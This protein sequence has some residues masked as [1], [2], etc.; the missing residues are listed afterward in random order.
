[1]ARKRGRSQA[2]EP[3]RRDSSAA[4]PA[5]HVKTA[6]EPRRALAN[7]ALLA[8]YYL[9]TQTLRQYA[10]SKLPSSSRIRR[11][12]I[13]SVGLSH[14]SPEK[15]CTEDELALGELLD[16]T[17]V[18]RRQ[19]AEIDHGH[20]W[21]QWVGFSQKGDESYVTL[22]DGLKGSIYSQSEVRQDTDSSIRRC[23]L[24]GAFKDC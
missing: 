18:A 12:K 11:K 24:H 7:N 6:H 13:A 21:Q 8:Q 2:G 5:K 20:R 22:S 3:D 23:N 1:V 15:A 17:I 19:N 9:E 14:S 16:S 4:R 10:L